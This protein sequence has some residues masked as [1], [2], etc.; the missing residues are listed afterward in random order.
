MELSQV[1]LRQDP[2]EAILVISSRSFLIFFIC[3]KG[4]EKNDT[5]FVHMR[6]G[7]HLGDAKMSKKDTSIR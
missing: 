7:G 2:L 3:L 5:T 1:F 4:L 6:N